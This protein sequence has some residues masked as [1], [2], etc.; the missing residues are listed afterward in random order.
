MDKYDAANDH[1][2]YQGTSVLKNKLNI[3]DEHKLELAERDITN[4]TINNV[5]YQSPPYD[6]EDFKSIHSTLFSNLYDWAGQIRDV[7]I[8]K[9][10]TVFCIYSR[11]EPEANKL[12]ESLAIDNYLSGLSRLNFSRKLAEYYCEFNMIHPFREGNGRVQR[13]FF[14]HLALSGGY[15]LDWQDVTKDE[16]VKANIDGVQVDYARMEVIF[17]RILSE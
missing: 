10:G 4:Q 13:V 6:L 11:I 7:S 5:I 8:S 14:E 1:Y 16:W 2:C 17:N 9:G 3:H 15:E 12:F